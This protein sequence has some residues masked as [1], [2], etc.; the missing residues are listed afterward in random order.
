MLGNN[1]EALYKTIVPEEIIPNYSTPEEQGRR[2]QR[3]SILRSTEV[4][5]RSS[6]AIET[7]QTD[8]LSKSGNCF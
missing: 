5:Y 4:E 3:C 2:I 8:L 1:Y 7:K 6:S